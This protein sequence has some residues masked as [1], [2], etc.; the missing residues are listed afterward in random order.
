MRSGSNARFLAA[1][2]R[3]FS[4]PL[5]IRGVLPTPTTGYRPPPVD[6]KQRTQRRGL[7]SA[8][9]AVRRTAFIE[10]TLLILG[11]GYVGLFRGCIGYSGI[12]QADG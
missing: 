10:R 11:C 8:A 3:L 6:D 1:V 7:A 5:S 9:S 2:A 4:G 12:S